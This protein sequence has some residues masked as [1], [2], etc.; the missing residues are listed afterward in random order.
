VVFI[1]FFGLAA[2]VWGWRQ[3]GG[4]K[5]NATV[6]SLQLVDYC[7]QCIPKRFVQSHLELFWPGRSSSGYGESLTYLAEVEGQNTTENDSTNA[8]KFAFNAEA[9]AMVTLKAW[10]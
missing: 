3:S 8:R 10:N 6:I 1:I 4:C 9:F 7:V 5:V 2:T